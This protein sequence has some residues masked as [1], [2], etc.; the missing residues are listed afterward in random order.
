M[1]FLLGAKKYFSMLYL[2]QLNESNYNNELNQLSST[3]TFERFSLL[4]DYLLIKKTSQ[5]LNKKEQISLETS[6]NLNKEWKVKLSVKHDMA[7]SRMISRGVTIYRDGCCTI[8]G[9][10]ISENNQ[11]N[12]TKPQKTFNLNLSFKN[13]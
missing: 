5:N 9:F 4:G 12:L 8:F 1:L 3:L 7:L 10:S 13:L 6:L 11:S 2:F